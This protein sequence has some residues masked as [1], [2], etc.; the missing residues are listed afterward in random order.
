MKLQYS[1]DEEDFLSHQLYMASKSERI[2][3]KR[4][5]NKWIVPGIYFVF[6]LFFL[7]DSLY[8]LSS[9]F[10]LFSIFWVFLYP[11]WERKRYRK[12]YL[13][14]I[15]DNYSERVGKTT[16]LEFTE[17][18]IL[19]KTD[20]SEAK[21][22]VS[23]I[24]GIIELKDCIFVHLKSGSSYIIPKNKISNSKEVKHY[25]EDLSKKLEINYTKELNWEWK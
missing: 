16:I 11:V 1:L 13:N 23:E 9:V 25:L 15:Q 7:K 3:K 17:S 19:A 5:R 12:H 4:M 24:K 20:S 18:S 2:Q 10:I 6:G 21:V 14:F 8:T 22:S